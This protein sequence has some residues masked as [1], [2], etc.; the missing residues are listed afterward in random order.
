[1]VKSTIGPDFLRNLR[2]KTEAYGLIDHKAGPKNRTKGL[3]DIQNQ[4]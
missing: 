2:Q 4:S 3:T 1:M